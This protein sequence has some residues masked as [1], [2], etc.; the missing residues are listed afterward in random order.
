MRRTPLPRSRGLT[1]IE[2]TIAL[3]VLAILATMAMPTLAERLARQRLSSL[4]ETLAMDLTEGRLE[5]VQSGRAL[6]VVFSG[7]TDWCYAV[8]RT[9]GCGCGTPQPCQLKVERAADWPGVTLEAASNV[10]LE[11]VGTPDLGA[12]IS[13]R[14]VGGRHQM[15]VSLSPLGRARTCTT[16]QLAGQVPC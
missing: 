10:Q 11:P 1:L 4:A 5:A 3:A 12:Q 6:H 16:T 13:F 7:D 8:T 15:Q 2:I 9:P 14:G